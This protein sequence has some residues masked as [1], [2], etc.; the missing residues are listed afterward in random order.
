[1]SIAEKMHDAMEEIEVEMTLVGAT[2][3]EDKLQVSQ[4]SLRSLVLH[5]LASLG[6][7][8]FHFYA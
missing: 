1:M 7:L 6:R 4:C 2:A 5:S 8:A 3:I